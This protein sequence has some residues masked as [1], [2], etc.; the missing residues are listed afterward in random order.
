MKR[1]SLFLIPSAIAIVLFAG[2]SSFESV[3]NDSES[4][5]KL[6]LLDYDAYSE[7]INSVLFD[8]DGSINYTL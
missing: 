6:I 3:G 1:L 2:I 4:Q 7:G 5:E 8:A